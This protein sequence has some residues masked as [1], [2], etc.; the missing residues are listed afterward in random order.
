M[1]R[2]VSMP[3]YA[4]LPDRLKRPLRTQHQHRPLI[5][6]RN[7][8]AIVTEN[9]H[10]AGSNPDFPYRVPLLYD[11]IEYCGH[12]TCEKVFKAVRAGEQPKETYHAAGEEEYFDGK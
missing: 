1:P 12:P 3:R 6:I 2:T 4:K 11:I 9:G 7:S 5:R 8:F 10:L